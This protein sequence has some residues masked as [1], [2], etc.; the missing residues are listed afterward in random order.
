M[1]LSACMKRVRIT[2]QAI[3]DVLEGFAA[4]GLVTTFQRAPEI[5]P[6]D[7]Q[8]TASS[9]RAGLPSRQRGRRG[10][11]LATLQVRLPNGETVTLSP[12]R[13]NPLIKLVIEE[14]WDY[15]TPAFKARAKKLLKEFS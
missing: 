15:E 2:E 6:S 13:D 11:E 14:R 5:S 8:P 9:C 1:G 7:S 12:D 10:R 3:R 4:S